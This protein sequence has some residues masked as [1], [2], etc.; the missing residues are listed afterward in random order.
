MF[1][2]DAALMEKI[3]EKSALAGIRVLMSHNLEVLLI[4]Y[5]PLEYDHFIT[6]PHSS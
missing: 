4:P 3:P 5:V 1:W 6:F 2:F